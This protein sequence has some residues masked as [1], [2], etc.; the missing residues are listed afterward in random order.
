[1]PLENIDLDSGE[2]IAA[3]PLPLDLHD[4]IMRSIDTEGINQTAEH[5]AAGVAEGYSRAQVLE[6]INDCVTALI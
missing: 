1:M 4:V 2:N 6:A 5:M 3:D